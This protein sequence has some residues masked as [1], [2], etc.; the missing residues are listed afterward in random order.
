M[1]IMIKNAIEKLIDGQDLNFDETKEVMNLIMSGEATNA[2]I[3]S[4]LTALRIK[5]ETPTE[6][7][8]CATV[9]RDKGQKLNH[10]FPVAEIV[11]TG[12]DKANTFNI[13]TASGFVVS[14]AG[15]PIAKHGN[16]S[17]SSKCGAADV[18]ESLGIKINLTP[19]QNKQVL[20]ECG[21]CFMFAQVYHS[22]MKYAA[23][24]RRELGTRTV[25]NILG[26]LANPAQA[27]INLIGVYDKALVRP[28]AEVLKKLGVKRGMVIYGLDGLDEITLTDKTI[29][30][31]INGDNLTESELD[32]T[33]YGFTLCDKSELVGGDA[34]ENAEII[35]AILSGEKGA[36]RDIVTL[37]S[38]V[39]LYLAG[40]ADSIKSG[41]E[42]A[43]ET[44]DSGKAIQQLKKLVKTTNSFDN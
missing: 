4:F 7:S 31:E 37:N 12:G 13:S 39:V 25:F 26:P 15:V 14:G 5:G 43:A 10:D 18:L 27:E 16:R 20:K 29:V 41:I 6:I 3:A 34:Q 19:E 21:M 8:A 9:M 11:G 32:P 22:S 23:P 2:Q 44:I 33:D 28:I 38:G 17:V 35:K 42:L 24:V 40:K 1:I 30:C 36:K